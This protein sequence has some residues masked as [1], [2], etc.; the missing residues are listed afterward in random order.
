MWCKAKE[1]ERK[2]LFWIFDFI[3]KKKKQRKRSFWISDLAKGNREMRNR[4]KVLQLFNTSGGANSDVSLIICGSNDSV[5]PSISAVP[6]MNH[7]DIVGTS[8]KL[9]PVALRYHRREVNKVF[10]RC[11]EPHLISSCIPDDCHSIKK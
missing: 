9:H 5:G 3:V 2:R 1:K 8:P 11:L 4:K 7:R 10:R 6:D